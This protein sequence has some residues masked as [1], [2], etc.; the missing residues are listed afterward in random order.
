[1]GPTGGKRGY[2]AITGSWHT[3]RGEVILKNFTP[4][5]LRKRRIVVVFILKRLTD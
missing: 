1:M 4:F 3:H 5:L 2:P